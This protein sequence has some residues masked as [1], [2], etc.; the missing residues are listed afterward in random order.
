MKMLLYE[1]S[2]L[3]N[4]EGFEC[5]GIEVNYNGERV[6]SEWHDEFY[7][8]KKHPGISGEDYEHA[9]KTF[10]K[11]KDPEAKEKIVAAIR[12]L[13]ESYRKYEQKLREDKV[14][15]IKM[16]FDVRRTQK[17]IKEITLEVHY[18]ER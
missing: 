6:G 1:V 2:M 11:Y 10:I 17:V 8:L 13:K 7:I 18:E 15:E 9:I 12:T 14:R 5:K 4:E 16:Y 3:L